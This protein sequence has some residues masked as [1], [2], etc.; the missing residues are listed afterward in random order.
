MKRRCRRARSKGI[1]IGHK[2]SF[3]LAMSSYRNNLESDAYISRTE[4]P[5]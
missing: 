1:Y 5:I 4:E 2:L 3:G